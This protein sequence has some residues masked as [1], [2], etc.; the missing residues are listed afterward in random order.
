MGM[1]LTIQVRVKT[2]ALSHNTR[3]GQGTPRSKITLKG[4]ACP[5]STESSEEEDDD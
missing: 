3:E 1:A 5:Q 2:P 4:W